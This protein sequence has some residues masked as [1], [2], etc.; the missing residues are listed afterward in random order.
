MATALPLDAVAIHSQQKPALLRAYLSIWTD[1]VAKNYAEDSP[2]LD[3]YDLFAG[4]GRCVEQEFRKDEWDGTAMVAATH[5]RAYP[6]KRPCNLVLNSWADKESDRLRNLDALKK[7]V[8]GLGLGGPRRRVLVMSH[9][10]SEALPEALRIH[11]RRM[12]YPSLWILDPYAAQTVPWLS[13]VS[14]ANDVGEYLD[15]RTG[16]KRRRRPELF[17]HFMTSSLQRNVHNPKI[18]AE[19]LGCSIDEWAAHAE[20]VQREGGTVLDALSSFYLSQLTRL[21]GRPPLSVKFSGKDGNPVSIAFIVVEH[22]AAWFMSLKEA[23]PQFQEWQ[24]E[25][26]EPRKEWVRLHHRYD[27]TAPDGQRQADLA[28]FEK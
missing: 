5:L 3:I 16:M 8:E 9:P 10:M 13:V 24:V 21:Y 23:L 20:R 26:Y 1:H 15:R 11:Q 4:S 12:K 17:L 6:S 7:R 22:N 28:E 18:I 2:S 14:I 19:A 27:R 25:K